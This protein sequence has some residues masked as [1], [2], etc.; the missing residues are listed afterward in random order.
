MKGAMA[1]VE[2]FLIEEGEPTRR[3]SLVIS[4]PERNGDE[5]GWSCRVVLADQHPP[6]T[7]VGRDSFEA[8]S[9]AMAR[10]RGWVDALRSGGRV[11]ARDRSGEIRF[12]FP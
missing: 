12:E 11:L 5:G 1:A 6:E 2:I 10:A 9:L 8:L 7:I 3:L 4:T